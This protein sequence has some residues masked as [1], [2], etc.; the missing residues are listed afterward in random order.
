[1][2]GLFGNFVVPDMLA[3]PAD[4]TAWAGVTP[5]NASV[6]LRSATSLVLDAT[7]GAYYDVDPLTGL[8]TD[9]A[10]AKVLNDATCIQAAAWD[11]I[12]YNPLTGGVLTAAVAEEKSIG[13][14]KLKY[15]DAGAAATSRAQAVAGLVPDALRKLAQ[16][17]L[18][19]STVW[20][21]G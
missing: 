13:S 19:A 5:T 14:A 20:M 9:T 16:N 17:N 10:V 18:L 11:A 21:Y 7:K 6:L 4:L 15:A 3:Q 1:M 12:K 2:A 8:A